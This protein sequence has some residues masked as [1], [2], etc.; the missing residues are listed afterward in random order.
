MVAIILRE[1]Q[2]R[3]SQRHSLRRFRAPQTATES[4]SP[5]ED[6]FPRAT[7]IARTPVLRLQPLR[8]LCPLNIELREHRGGA[9]SH[10]FQILLER[11]CSG[12]PL[13]HV[14]DSALQSFLIGRA[15][16]VCERYNQIGVRGQQGIVH[17][18]RQLVVGF[19]W[20]AELE[21]RCR[22]YTTEGSTAPSANTHAINTV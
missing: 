9:R 20:P 21:P 6:S 13:V 16:S 7:L 12:A 5:S 4:T 18:G 22:K 11:P 1:P 2:R 14:T 3:C 19:G 8:R 17:H 10:P 15:V